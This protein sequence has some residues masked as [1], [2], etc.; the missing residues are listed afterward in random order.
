MKK[1]LPLPLPLALLLAPAVLFA[2]DA[3]DS[4]VNWSQIVGVI[5]APNV[6]NPV[7]GFNSGAGPWSTRD[8]HARVNLA[9]GQASFDVEGLVL[10]GGNS[11]GTPGPVNTVAGTLVCDAGTNAQTVFD[12]VEVALNLQ[13]NAHF[14]G[15]LNGIPAACENPLFLVRIGPS[16]P[17][18]GA[19]GRWLA[20]G[21][22]RTTGDRY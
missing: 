22:V 4:V 12:T 10:N 18:R 5:T 8:G 9:T 17:A 3:D 13:G 20:T 11:S 6:N 2:Q 15:H 21:A 7:A 16:F 1:L 19:V 14:R